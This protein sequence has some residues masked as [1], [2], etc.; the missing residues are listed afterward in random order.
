MATYTQFKKVTSDNIVDATIADADLA[1]NSVTST[2]INN[3]A[4][5]SSKIASG[6]VSDTELAATLDLSGKTVTYRAITNGDIS[7]GAAIDNS[8]ISG[9]GSL[10]TASAVG[11]SQIQDGAVTSGKLSSSGGSAYQQLQVNAA[12]N[13]LEFSSAG[14]VIKMA[15]YQNT[16]RVSGVTN[17]G[18]VINFGNY[19]K[20]SST[21]TLVCQLNV[22]YDQTEDSDNV[23][24]FTQWQNS[25][26]RSELGVNYIDHENSEGM[27]LINQHCA[28]AAGASAGNGNLAVGHPRDVGAGVGNVLNPTNA[29]DG[30]TPTTGSTLT[31]WE[32]EL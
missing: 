32:V 14:R 24:Y 15:T 20:I 2:K 31:V 3:G 11:T 4:V 5:T 30:R 6:A 21:S 26:Y 22:T 9:L 16:T 8:K 25:S 10:A 27:S 13:A 29:D 28:I 17:N 23:S 18:T 7:A 1:S 12:G 19:T